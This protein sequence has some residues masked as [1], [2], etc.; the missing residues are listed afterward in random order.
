MSCSCDLFTCTCVADPPRTVP[1]PTLN[2]AAPRQF[3]S[4]DS[5][6][7]YYARAA[8]FR[9]T[10]MS[11]SLIG[12]E[13]RSLVGLLPALVI[14]MPQIHERAAGTKQGA[15]RKKDVANLIYSTGRIADR[16]ENVVRMTPAEW[17][18]QLDKKID[19][20]R[21]YNTLTVPE[22]SIINSIKTKAERGHVM[23]AVGLGLKYLW[24]R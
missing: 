14:E 11:V 8:W 21:T 1:L 6:V 2:P 24:R 10:L 13:Q 4:V 16:Y 5:G 20:E 3:H 17:K 12:I 9:G 23:D 19:H 18:G 7:A 15:A 22:R